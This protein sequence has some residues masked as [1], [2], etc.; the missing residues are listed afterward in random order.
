MPNCSAMR[1]CPSACAGALA[2]K[3]ATPIDKVSSAAM[4]RRTY[5]GRSA[6]GRNLS[7]IETP[8]SV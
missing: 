6:V 7:G 1:I 5:D 3:P 8:V 4:K 2:A